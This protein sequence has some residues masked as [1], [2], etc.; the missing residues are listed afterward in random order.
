MLYK[1]IM[2]QWVEVAEKD[3]PEILA[4]RKASIKTMTGE[5]LEQ[6]METLVKK[7]N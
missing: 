6:Y 7:G 4:K 3:L 5:R 1:T 2:G